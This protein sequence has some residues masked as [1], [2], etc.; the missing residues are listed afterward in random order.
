VPSANVS[1]GEHSTRGRF[2]PAALD[3]SPMRFR[4]RSC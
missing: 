4:T 2:T 1:G 3:S